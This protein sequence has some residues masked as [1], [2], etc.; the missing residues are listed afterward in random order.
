MVTTAWGPAGNASWSGPFNSQTVARY[1][2]GRFSRNLNAQLNNA[3]TDYLTADKNVDS[4]RLLR[5]SIAQSEDIGLDSPI[6]NLTDAEVA[7]VPSEVPLIPLDGSPAPE[8][9]PADVVDSALREKL[10]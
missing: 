4:A 9:I 6:V 7:W 3:S 1:S 2:W 8:I 10:S 5:R